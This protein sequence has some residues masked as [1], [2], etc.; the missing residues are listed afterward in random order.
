MGWLAPVA[1]IVGTGLQAAGQMK[2][3]KDAK[4]A[5]DLQAKMTEQSAAIDVQ[6]ISKEERVMAGAQ[7]AGYAKA[8]VK[9]SGSA[10]D[11]ML[12]TATNYEFD[13]MV[14]K[15]NARTQAGI[16]RYYGKVAQQQGMFSS[17]MTLLGMAKAIPTFGSS[18]ENTGYATIA[19]VGRV[20]VSPTD[21]YLTH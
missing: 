2:A 1:S 17:G 14:T 9:V 7:K 5:Y 3:G 8:G 16:S 11:V 6:N 21:Y 12:N 18:S 20:P 15:Y 4:S 13:K 10:L 19:G